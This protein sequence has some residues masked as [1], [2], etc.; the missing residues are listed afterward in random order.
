MKTLQT[1]ILVIG[2]GATG[3]GIL[4]D[5]AM[6]GFKAILVEK[7]DLAHGTTGRYHGLLHSGGRYVV[8]DPQAARECIEENHILRRIMPHCIEDTGGFFVVTPWDDP[9]YVPRFLD[10]CRVAGIPVESLSITDMLREEP[11]LNSQ[12]THC[13]RVPDGSADSFKAAASN[14]VS[15]REHGAMV[16][17]YTIVQRLLVNKTQRRV[18]GAIC[19]DRQHDEELT[20][21][22]DLVVNASGAWAGKVAA[23]AGVIVSIVGGKGTMVA[24]NHRIVN[25]VINRCKMPADGDILVPAHTV[26]VIGTTDVK[27]TDPDNYG[28]E[29][30]EV[31]LCLEEGSKII[32]GFRDMR[33]LRAWAGVR[34]LYQESEVSDTRD[35]TRAFVLLDHAARDDLAGLVTITSGKWTTYRKMAQV[36]VDLVCQKLGVQRAC[37]THEEPLPAED[38]AHYH[39]LGERLK[40]I[41][42]DARFGNL[43]CECELATRQEVEHAIVEGGA[44]TIDDVRRAVRLGMGPCQGGFCTYRVAGILHHLK[45]RQPSSLESKSHVEHT[46]LALFDF[47]QERWKG[48]LPVLWGQQL[49]QERLDE[50]IYLS[51]LNIH[52]LP[53]PRASRLA[54]ERYTDPTTTY[55]LANATPKASE[56]P[57]ETPFE[58][59]IHHQPTAPT[60]N[61]V[62]GAGLAGL[63]AAWRLAKR[64]QRVRVISKGWGSIYWQP[65]CIDVLGYYPLEAEKLL[66]SPRAG[67]GQLIQAEP[68][69]PYAIAIRQVGM[70][71]IANLLDEFKELCQQAGY[72]LCG[73]LD[74]NWLLPTAAGALRPTCLA[75]YSMIA[76]AVGKTKPEPPMLIAGFQQFPDFYPEL[77]AANLDQQ[78]IPARG[79]VMDVSLLAERRFVTGR[80]LANLFERVDFRE[81]ISAALKQ[82]LS[83][84]PGVARI[85]FPAVLGLNHCIEVLTDLEQRLGLPVFE[86]PTLPPSIPGIRLHTILVEAIRRLGGE[87]FEGMQ[88]IGMTT[89]DQ[90]VNAIWVEAAARRK[91]NF[92]QRFILATGGILGGG[93]FAEYSGEL[94]EVIAHIPVQTT[95]PVNPTSDRRR[96][97]FQP[98]FLAPKGQPVFRYGIGVNDNFQPTD[99]TG[100]AR[101]H[102]LYAIGATLTA[103][104]T[105]REFSQGGV[106][107]VTGAVLGDFLD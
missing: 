105:L 99:S 65:G 95:L 96:D 27:I 62:V 102:N 55:M 8:K 86:I 76:G 63:T 56:Q 18:V 70:N 20:I 29:P 7:G 42:E 77:I 64:G 79:I 104:E 80:V 106:S 45:N 52:H 81:Q 68:Q 37:R 88:A 60:G 87:V 1:E 3:T 2:G 24:M 19:Y 23:S 22:A 91:P 35:V 13:F 89:T 90:R 74:E 59:L 30:W 28:I 17:S 83:Q 32:P 11:L 97:W 71:G 69:H 12:I 85:G 41:E 82:H 66:L 31:H 15:A 48:L 46:N 94:R 101:Y 36:T 5:L 44:A 39:H 6:R 16:L 98:D 50:L 72:P 67:L 51:V 75:P 54:P 34:P 92:A 21:S 107:L 33:M 49:R 10:G 93:I 40:R 73:S 43:V 26:S 61:L 57:T 14:A 100:S 25:T 58:S 78:N 47:L 103:A 53:G 9:A 84:Y 4:R 38:G